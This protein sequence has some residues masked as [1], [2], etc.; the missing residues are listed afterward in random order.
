MKKVLTTGITTTSQQPYTK[1]THDWYNAMTLEATEAIVKSLIPSS[2]YTGKLVVL[3]GCVLT[4]TNPG[5]RTI[6]AGWVW[7]NGEIYKVDAATF[8]TTTLLPIGVW[9][10]V[11]TDTPLTFSDGSIK[12]VHRESKFRISAALAGTGLFDEN[13]V[14]IERAGAWKNGLSSILFFSIT[15]DGLL[16]NAPN[17]L[18]AYSI[19]NRTLF[20][21]ALIIMTVTDATMINSGSNISAQL[22]FSKINEFHAVSFDNLGDLGIAAGGT[23][24]IVGTASSRD[25]S[26]SEM[27]IGV[28]IRNASA[29][30]GQSLTVKISGSWALL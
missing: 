11:N 27:R 15:G 28:S 24:D 6:T 1:Q 9:A 5:I 13:N 22:S 16:L 12:P 21:K 4:G 17:S 14:N 19:V 8:T 3:N 20:Y 23:G 18:V 29:V 26:S 10:I 25:N 2:Y 7:Y 30:N